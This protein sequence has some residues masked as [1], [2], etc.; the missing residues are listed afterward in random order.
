MAKVQHNR[1]T[2]AWMF[3]IGFSRNTK[4]ANKD[5]FHRDSHIPGISVPFENMRSLHDDVI[6]DFPP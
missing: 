3:Q 6:L 4:C 2:A 1:T 5:G